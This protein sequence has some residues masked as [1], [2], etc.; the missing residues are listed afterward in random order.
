MAAE[1]TAV[2][3]RKGSSDEH[4]T[5][6]GV[7]GEITVDLTNLTVWVHPGGNEI[8]NPLA[9]ADMQNVEADDIAA[10]G[11]ALNSLKNLTVSNTDLPGIKLKLEIPTKTSQ[12]ENDSGYITDVSEAVGDATITLKKN[13]ATIGSFTT[14]S[15]MNTDINIPVPTSTSELTNNSGF[16]TRTVTNLT[17]Y[18]KTTDLASVAISGSYS[19]LGDRPDFASVATSGSY[20]DL[21]N[22]PNL[23]SVATTGNY[24][25][26]NN[27]PVIVQPVR[28]N[29][30]EA[31]PSELAYVQNKPI[32]VKDIQVTPVTGVITIVL[33]ESFIDPE[34]PTATPLIKALVGSTAIGGTWADI[35]DT[36]KKQWTFTPTDPS[37]ILD[38][39]WV[40]V[41]NE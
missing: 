25:D 13:N 19:D 38:D 1:A 23:A 37:D 17:N 36:D 5:F 27:R 40:I 34:D 3:F 28:S 11:I 2:S 22:T 7:K 6:R 12:L 18:T 32:L 41:V 24:E 10:R 29:W 15:F 20:T 8:G 9:R 33:S 4:K 16:I 35:A 14:N 31:D 39:S 30:L 21:I 26:L